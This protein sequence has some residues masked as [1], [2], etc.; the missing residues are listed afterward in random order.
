MKIKRLLRRLMQQSALA[1]LVLVVLSSAVRAELGKKLS[2]FDASCPSYSPVS[3]R[4][5]FFHHADAAAPPELWLM[6]SEGNQ[7]ERLVETFQAPR[8]MA[9]SPDGKALFFTSPGPT[10]VR[11]EQWSLWKLS[12][13]TRLV[14]EVYTSSAGELVTPRISPDG[15]KIALATEKNVVVVNADGSAPRAIVVNARLPQC[16]AWS[17]DSR[18]IAYTVSPEWP[19][20]KAPYSI[21][22]RIGDAHLVDASGEKQRLVAR[23]SPTKFLQWSASGKYLY[24]LMNGEIAPLLTHEKSFVRIATEEGADPEVLIDFKTWEADVSCFSFGDDAKTIFYD[25]KLGGGCDFEEGS[26]IYKISF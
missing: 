10:N 25:S 20:N 15:R 26:R 2:D 3:K 21:D 12:L 7:R 16:Q 5:A 11:S 18:T 1:C 23:M 13:Q 9:W 6:D 22:G 17:P 19:I 4:I 24:Y 14:Q 8:D